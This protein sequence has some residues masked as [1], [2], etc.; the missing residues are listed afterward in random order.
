[1]AP[2]VLGF[3]ALLALVFLGLPVA[4]AMALIGFAGM[5]TLVDYGAAATHVALIATETVM[6]YTFSVAALFILMGNLVSRARLSEEL[7]VAAYAFVGHR[8][9]GLAMATILA[10]GGFSAVSGSSI[11]TAATMA[12]IAMPQ[13]RARGYADGLAAGSIA[14]GGTLGIL[15]P[16]S[17]AL[18]IY[19]NLTETDVGKLFVAGILPGILGIALYV[20]AVA[21]VTAIRPE[22]GP[23]GERVAWRQRLVVLKGVWGILALFAL[24]MGGVYFGMFTPTEAAGIGAAGALLFALVRRALTLKSLIDV[25]QETAQ[26]TA[27]L[28]IMIVGAVL[29][30][31]FMNLAGLPDAMAAFVG[32][33]DIAPIGVMFVIVVIYVVLGC[34][35]DA[36]AMILLTVPILAP[37]VVALG[38]DLIWFGII[39]VVVAEI[40]LITPP[41]GI[42]VFVLKAILRDI[43]DTTIFR[44]VV[45]FVLVDLV[46]VALL[47]LAP[48]FVLYLPSFMD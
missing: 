3:V 29:F 25:L 12:P 35:F 19:G 11:A 2:V 28:L 27:A 22:D 15:I 43:T 36:F 30:S 41:I 34:V 4:F 7:Y 26:T 8:R 24:V 38:Y 17:I 1:M 48:G 31:T 21:G 14:A 42:N 10:C 40:A 5:A 32:G 9:G 6:N 45:P 39:V 13:M 37:L 33:L 47:V 23:R 46:R 18:V 20:A 16:P 44:G